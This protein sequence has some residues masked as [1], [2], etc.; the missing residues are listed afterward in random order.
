V[1]ALLAVVGVGAVSR[2]TEDAGRRALAAMATRGAGAQELRRE[3]GILLGVARD[4]WQE[5]PGLAGPARVVEAHGY[6]AVSD[7]ALFYRGDLLRKLR[8]AGMVPVEKSP[9]HL[10]AATFRAFPR[11]PLGPLE[12]DF[13]LLLWEPASRTLTAARDPF[14]PRPLF[15]A[16]LPGGWAVASTPEGLL[17]LLPGG[18]EVDPAGI[19]RILTLRAGDGTRTAWRGIREL[20]AGHRLLLREGR[21]PALQRFW[22]PD[23]P[24]GRG[25]RGTEGPAAE[26]LAALLEESTVERLGPEGTALALSGGR[27]ST[28]LLGSL[29]V[30][31]R[32]DPGIP[33]FHLLSLRYPPGDPGNEDG[34]IA[35]TVAFWE[36]GTTWIDTR[37]LPLLPEPHGGARRRSVPLP[38]VYEEQN[39]ALA[40]GALR[41]GCRVLLNGHGGDNL[42]LLGPRWMADLVRT[43]RWLRFR[44]EWRERGLAGWGDFREVAVRPLIPHGALRGWKWLR[45]LPP[46]L[47]P[48]EFP[49]PPWIPPERL[50]ALGIAAEDREAVRD[51]PGSRARL[52]S[53][54]DRLWALLYPAFHQNS[55]ALFQVGVEEGVELRSPILDRRVVEFTLSRPSGEL[56][57]GREEK[58][59]LRRAMQGRVPSSVLVHRAR[60][61]G[62]ADGYFTRELR[63]SLPPLAWILQRS[64]RLEGLGLVDPDRLGAAVE[65][66]GAGDDGPGLALYLT[67]QVELWLREWTEDEGRGHPPEM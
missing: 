37:D 48:G 46:P 60:R 64:S 47:L 34:Y 50:E 30:R 12:G 32:T 56:A 43:G 57:R 29:E 66:Y 33:R 9:S 63:R 52:P 51:F 2:V 14:G 59:L 45:G 11:D 18:G 8:G 65:R 31:R 41:G 49:L 15:W 26:E 6:L 24:E 38:L 4:P 5:H 55:A 20:P 1:S 28:A 36:T 17:G 35:D 23:P 25:G 19:L 54:S 10:A 22:E 42:F 58:W 13:A 21:P 40:R 62:T 39:R 53:S 61:T 67:L 3:E 16:E 27:D 44:R 7:A